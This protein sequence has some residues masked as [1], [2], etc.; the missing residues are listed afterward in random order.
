MTTIKAGLF[1]KN[2]M[3]LKTGI[4]TVDSDVLTYKTTE[5]TVFALPKAEVHISFSSYGTLTVRSGTQKWIFV[6]GAYS[7]PFPPSFTTD[8]I[9]EVSAGENSI[10]LAAKTRGDEVIFLGRRSL[11]IEPVVNGGRGYGLAGL[12]LA[13]LQRSAFYTNLALVE[14]LEAQ[15]FAVTIHSKKFIKAQGYIL[16]LM[17]AFIAVTTP[18][19]YWIFDQFLD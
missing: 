13:R 15:G 17:V 12:L 5:T 2:G 19:L 3:N 14:F 7:G 6:A 1:L 18:I 9:D 11:G 16:L 10:T 4:L 8:Q